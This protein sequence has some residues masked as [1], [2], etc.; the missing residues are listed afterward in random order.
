MSKWPELN[1][2]DWPSDIPAHYLVALQEGGIDTLKATAMVAVVL[3]L[4]RRVDE[5]EKKINRP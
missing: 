5:L 1:D 3:G 4:M 2:R